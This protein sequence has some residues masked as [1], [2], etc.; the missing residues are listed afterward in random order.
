MTETVSTTPSQGVEVAPAAEAST[1]NSSPEVKVA[2]MAEFDPTKFTPEQIEQILANQKTKVKINGK[3]RE[4]TYAEM[5]KLASINEAANEKFE[6]AK[7]SQKELEEFRKLVEGGDLVKL[8]K[9]QGK[10]PAEIKELLTNKVLDLMEEE[11]LDP[12][13]KLL[14]EYEAKEKARE[15]AEKA[16]KE[17]QEANKKQTEYQKAVQQ[18]EMELVEA[19]KGTKLPSNDPVFYKMVVQEMLASEIAGVEMSASE[20]A[21][22]VEGEVIKHMT[23]LLP[24]LGLDSIKQILGK[25]FLKSLREESVAEVKKESSPFAKPS[26]AKQEKPSTEKEKKVTINDFF[27]NMREQAYKK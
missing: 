20:A 9:S 15:E 12:R 24:K 8:Y 25:E 14:R 27:R 5:K 6:I 3:D 17:A 21:K 18:A 11:E 22:I 1:P 10:T 23:A 19:M 16:E 2:A 26:A 13:E 4:L 7:K